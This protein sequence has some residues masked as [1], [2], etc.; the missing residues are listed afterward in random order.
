MLKRAGAASAEMRM[1]P[2]DAGVIALTPEQLE[3]LKQWIA[4]GAKYEQHWSFVQPKLPSLPAVSD[5]RWC[6]NPVDRF[7]LAKLDA[8]NL[9]P[10]AEADPDTLAMRASVVLTGLAPDPAELARYRA[11][12]GKGAYERFVD[13]LLASPAYGE[14]QA[15]YWLDAV[16]YGDTHGLHIDN[17]RGIYPYRDWVVSAF[18]RDLP[19]NKFVEW[20]LA[21]DLLP[22]PTTEQLVATGYVRMNPT[23]N[24]GGAIEEEFLARNTMDRVD[25]TSTVM[26][27]LT[28]A[29]A[30]CHDHKYDP[31]KQRDYYGL[32]AFFDST[33]DA[34]LDGNVALPPPTVRAATPDQEKRLA[35]LAKQVQALTSKVQP[36]AAATWFATH[37][38]PNPQTKGWEISPVYKSATFDEAF[39]LAS[40]G[41]PGQPAPAWKPVDFTIGKPLANIIGKDNASVYVRGT[42]TV[43]ADQIITIGVS[44]DDGVRLWLNGKLVH[45]NKAL[46]S[47][48]EAIDQ[49]K[50]DLRAGDNELVAKVINASGEDGLNIQMG[51]AAAARID[52]VVAAFRKMPADPKARL[53][54]QTAFLDSGPD[55]KDAVDY[56]KLAKTESEF[57]ASIPMTLIAREMDKPRPTFVLRRGQYDLKGDPVDRH[58]PAVLGSLPTGVPANRLS[59]AEWMVS[60]KNPLVSRVF[61]NRLWQQ[62]FG[63]GIVKTSEDFGSQGEWPANQPL[64]DYLAVD[65]MKQGWSIKRLNRMLVTSAAFRQSSKSTL[66]KLSADPENRLISRGPR[67]R[68]DAEVIRDRALAAG[69]ILNRSMGGRGFK[70]YQ[71]DGLWEAVA[72][73]ISDTAKYKRDHGDSIYRRSLY[74]FWKRTSPHPV[75]LNFD[76]PMRDSCIVRRTRT[77]TPLQ[78]LTTLNEPMFLE[79]CR[80]MA[81]HLVAEPVAD[82]ARLDKAFELTLGRAPSKQEQAVLLSALNRYHGEYAASE[83]AAK[84]LLMV[85]DSPQA[86]TEPPAD[87]ASW[88]LICSTLMNTD[89]FLSLH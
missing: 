32:Y 44:S 60:P 79:A 55:T 19:Y 69:G 18:N 64:L 2:P 9:K 38:K 39:E 26:L 14:H 4:S 78:A 20:Q 8:A 17:E 68:L 82:A 80:T 12:R 37:R 35:Q 11:D 25:T 87:V 75:M 56:R 58:L 46:R 3:T 74:L 24:E 57:E 84:S 31:I 7:V 21:G 33:Q 34:P 30:K 72:F 66:A 63:T 36:E 40:P 52:K 13:R 67:Y 62:A 70:P 81:Q 51:D 73:D 41:E 83:K 86:P 48:A 6:R 28:V 29:C 85:G 88:M 47:V 22:K 59:L 1:P 65:F 77:N 53:D 61:V 76:A 16:R 10:E 5:P 54:L 15:R 49:V 89:E 42:I 23:S 27:G 50:L 45:S 43:P 71:P